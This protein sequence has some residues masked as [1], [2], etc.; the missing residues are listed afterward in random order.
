MLGELF[1]PPRQRPDL[2][3]ADVAASLIA[4]CNWGEIGVGCARSVPD[5]LRCAERTA[6]CLCFRRAWR[7]CDQRAHVLSIG[8]WRVFF[9]ISKICERRMNNLRQTLNLCIFY[10][11][12]KNCG[13]IRI[14]LT[15]NIFRTVL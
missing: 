8:A 15:C 13:S 5:T 3:F 1:R 11:T 2:S 10:K 14:F 7:M 12:S 4:T 6:L 9:I